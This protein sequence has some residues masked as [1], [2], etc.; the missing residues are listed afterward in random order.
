MC[1][2]CSCIQQ[3]AIAVDHSHSVVG[4]SIFY[5]CKKGAVLGVVAL[6]DLHS[7]VLVMHL[8]AGHTAGHPAMVVVNGSGEKGKSQLEAKSSVWTIAIL[9]LTNR[10]S[11]P[12][13]KARL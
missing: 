2:I 8:G 10:I 3:A 4:W 7:N 9:C 13:Y 6:L 1:C 11:E 5:S 12:H